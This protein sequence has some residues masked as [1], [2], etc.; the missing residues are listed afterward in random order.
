MFA[1]FLDELVGCRLPLCAGKSLFPIVTRMEINT[2][3][4]AVANAGLTVVWGAR[5]IGLRLGD[6]SVDEH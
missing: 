3:I 5:A 1:E 6:S 4:T 2:M